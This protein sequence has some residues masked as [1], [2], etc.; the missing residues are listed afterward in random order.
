MSNIE[1]WLVG[2]AVTGAVAIFSPRLRVWLAGMISVYARRFYAWLFLNMPALLLSRLDYNSLPTEQ[3]ALLLA[4]LKNIVYYLVR[5][6]E[7]LLPDAGLGEEKKA[8][9]LA[10][11]RQL[12]IPDSLGGMAAG[13]INIAVETM[14]AEA[15]AA[16]SMYRPNEA[17]ALEGGNAGRN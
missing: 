7:I 10:K 3:Q 15:Q 1:M 16:L 9:V 13:M 5:I 6:E 8:R 11:L 12:G 14:N 2:T 4:A 17:K